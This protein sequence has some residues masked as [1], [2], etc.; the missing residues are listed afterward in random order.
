MDEDPD[1][2][3]EASRIVS[4]I[5]GTEQVFIVP[6]AVELFVKLLTEK[7]PFKKIEMSSILIAIL[8]WL[9]CCNNDDQDDDESDFQVFEKSESGNSQEWFIIREIFLKILRRELETCSGD[10]DQI[11]KICNEIGFEISKNQVKRILDM[12][13]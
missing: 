1:I 10:V 7:C 6:H 4:N 12:L 11:V 3:E 13:K 8:H 9:D 5:A 2:S